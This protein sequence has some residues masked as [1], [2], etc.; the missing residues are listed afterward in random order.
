MSDT[1]RGH[2]L[3]SLAQLLPVLST[4][5]V[6]SRTREQATSR[7]RRRNAELPWLP[8]H[9]EAQD[10]PRLSTCKMLLRRQGCPIRRWPHSWEQGPG[11]DSEE[12]HEPASD[13]DIAVVDSLKVLDPK[14][15][16]READINRRHCDVRRQKPTL[17]KEGSNADF[18][19]LDLP[20]P[21]RAL[22]LQCLKLFNDN[23]GQITQ[24]L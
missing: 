9:V 13:I 1:R 2:P 18:R 8:C 14:W 16:I 5:R 24:L 11:A 17:A 3:G 10:P 23:K 20:R 6:R 4:D 15:P 21:L 12:K 22:N 19:R 7:L